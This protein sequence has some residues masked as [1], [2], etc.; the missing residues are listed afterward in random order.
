MKRNDNTLCYFLRYLCTKFSIYPTLLAPPSVSRFGDTDRYNTCKTI[1]QRIGCLLV[2]RRE[3]CLEKKYFV[4][5]RF[6]F[7]FSTM[8]I[9]IHKSVNVYSTKHDRYKHLRK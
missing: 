3:K 7:L 4:T 5:I 9:S 1:V 2:L 6:F 8:N